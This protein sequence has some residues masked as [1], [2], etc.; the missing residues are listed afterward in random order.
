MKRFIMVFVLLDNLITGSLKRAF[1]TNWE[2]TGK[3]KICGNCCKEILLKATPRQINSPLFANIAVRWI[4]WL[5][6]FILIRVD[7]ENNYLAFTCK[8]ITPS[9]KCGNYF[10]RPSVCRNYP[11]LDYFDEPKFLPNCGYSATKR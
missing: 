5:F 10:W 4:S 1:P 7:R 11:L 8:H 2:R 3:C 6:D 9:G